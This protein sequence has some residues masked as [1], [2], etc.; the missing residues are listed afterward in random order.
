MYSLKY[1]KCFWTECYR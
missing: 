1:N